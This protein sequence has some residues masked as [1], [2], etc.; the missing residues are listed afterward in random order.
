[1]VSLAPGGLRKYAVT[2]NEREAVLDFH[3]RDSSD[4]KRVGQ[5]EFSFTFPTRLATYDLFSDS[6]RFYV[7]V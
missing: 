1:M 2:V 3:F 4:Q 7:D 5:L 6:L